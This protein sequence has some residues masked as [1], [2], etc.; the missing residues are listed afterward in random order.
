LLSK[1][2]DYYQKKDIIDGGFLESLKEEE[3]NLLDEILLSKEAI[4]CDLPLE[5]LLKLMDEYERLKKF[6][7][8]REAVKENPDTEGLSKF[9]KIRNETVI[10]K[11]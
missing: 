7:I 9:A 6:R 1:I 11:E 4:Y 10:H 2:H 3:K 8:V 5:E